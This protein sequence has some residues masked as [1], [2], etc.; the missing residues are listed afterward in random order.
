MLAITIGDESFDNETQRFVTLNPVTLK[1]E[2]SLVSVSKW[3]SKYKRPF[4]SPDP[5]TAEETLDYVRM[6]LITEDVPTAVFNRMRREHFDA[7][8][9]YIESEESATTFAELPDRKGPGEVVTAELIYYWMVA[10]TIPFECQYWHLKRL[11]ALIRI[12]NVKQDGKKQKKM[13]QHEIAQRY[14]AINAQRKAELGT[15]G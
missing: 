8:Q 14:Q 5:L 7:V 1:F 3:E 9:K 10:F 2:H 12:C 4:L 15:S 6:M 11:F 13:S